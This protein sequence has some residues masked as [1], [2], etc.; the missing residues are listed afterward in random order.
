[1]DPIKS[2]TSLVDTQADIS[3]M[4]ISD[5]QFNIILNQNEILSINGITCNAK[6]TLGTICTNLIISNN[7]IQQVF[8]VVNDDFNIPA[9]V[10]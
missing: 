2:A 4:K 8:H 5:L 1:M 3:L 7:I 9:M 10:F 6:S